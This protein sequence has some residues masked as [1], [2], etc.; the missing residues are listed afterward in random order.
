MSQ[1]DRDND[2]DCPDDT[3]FIISL[4]KKYKYWQNTRNVCFIILGH[5]YLQ[6]ALHP[7]R[8]ETAEEE[9]ALIISKVLTEVIL[10]TSSL[11]MK[12]IINSYFI[13]N[14][15]WLKEIHALVLNLQLK[16]FCCQSHIIVGVYIYWL[17]LLAV[18]FICTV[19][20]NRT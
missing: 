4:F 19:C 18:L 9:T 12:A 16:H 6:P 17:Y 3:D 20:M 2:D 10:M 8:E 1:V 14:S 7:T 5:L 15:W 11:I 13:M